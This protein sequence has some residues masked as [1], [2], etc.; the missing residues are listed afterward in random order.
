MTWITYIELAKVDI[1]KKYP[2]IQAHEIPDEQFRTL[3]GG[4]GEIF[5]KIRGVELKM[6]VPKNE[7][8]IH[9]NTI[10]NAAFRV[11]I[12]KLCVVVSINSRLN[13]NSTTAK[14]SSFAPVSLA[15][16]VFIGISSDCPG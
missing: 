10:S 2:D 7:F 11:Y 14:S 12:L 9:D 5:V 3:P 15:L 6:R 13:E 1:L 4:N 16:M 8:S